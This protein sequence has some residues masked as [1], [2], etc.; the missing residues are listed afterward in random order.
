MKNLLAI[1]QIRL[2]RK[3]AALLALGI[4]ALAAAPVAT[5]APTLRLTSGATVVTV[6]DGGANDSNPAAGAITYVG[7]VG[8]NWIISADT[9]RTKP[10]LG[11]ATE[12]EI[13]LGTSSRSLLAG[14]LTIEFSDDGFGPSRGN[15]TVTFGG[16]I[17]GNTN[18]T[19]TNTTLVN[20][21]NVLFGGALLTNLGPYMRP[22]GVSIYAFN[23]TATAA[24]N[25]AG[26][27]SLT[28]RMVIVH[29]SGGTSGADSALRFIPTAPT[30]GKIGN[31]VW[32]DLNANGVQDPL[33]PGIDGVT[34]VLTDG[35][36]TPITSTVTGLNGAYEFPGLALGTYKVSVDAGSAPLAG[37]LPSPTGAG[38]PAT[39]SNASP[40]TVTLTE[41]NPNDDSVD[42]GFYLYV[43]PTG[44]IGDYV[45]LDL[46][47][48]GIQDPNESGI[49]NVVVILKDGAGQFIESTHTAADGSYLF[50]GKTAGDYIVQ[51]D[52]STLP[53]GLIPTYSYVLGSFD[54]NDSNDNPYHVTLASKSDMDLTV[55][56][57]YIPAPAGSIGD[58]VWRD[59]DGDG[60][61]DNALLEPGIPGVLVE[62]YNADGTMLLDTEITD[63][64][65]YYLFTGLA[66]GTYI[67][68][69]PNYVT[70]AGYVY[71]LTT[72]N[73]AG[74]TTANDSNPNPSTVTLP[75]NTS[76][77]TDV[78]FGYTPVP[79]SRIG[80]FVWN[81]ANDNGIQDPTET[82]IGGVSVYLFNGDDLNTAIQTTVT[83]P[84]GSYW[85]NDLSSGIYSVAVDLSSPSLAG[86]IATTPNSSGDP[87][88]D[89]NLNP[90]TVT[91]LTNTETNDAIDFGF[92]R[93]AGAIGD[94][95]WDDLDFDGVQDANEP[96]I[97]GVTVDLYDFDNSLIASQ[98]TAPDGSYLFTGLTKG[99]YVVVVE[100][101]QFDGTG[102][103]PTQVNASGNPATDSNNNPQAV[104]LLT[105]ISVDDT[106]DF[107][108]FKPRGRIGNF[109][110]FDANQD[111][112]QSNGETGIANV[113]VKLLDSTNTEIGSVLT[114]ADGSYEFSGLLKGTYT[115]VVDN[116][117][118]LTAGY[119]PTNTNAGAPDVDSNVNPATVTLDFNDSVDLTIDFGYVLTPRGSIGDFVWNDINANG[120]QDGSESGIQG[121]TIRLN[122]PGNLVM[123]TT[124]DTGGLYLFDGLSAGTYTVTVVTSTLP[125]GFIASPTS[126]PGSNSGNDS[127]VNPAT[128][129]FAT[130]TASNMTIDFGYNKPSPLSV[131]CPARA[132]VFGQ[133]YTSFAVASG[134]V[135]PYTFT[136]ISGAL[137]PG[138]TLNSA[139]G[140]IAGTPTSEGSYSFTIQV[141]D[142]TRATAT[143][144]IDCCGGGSATIVSFNTPTGTLPASQT[145]NVAGV[146]ITAYGFA[147][148]GTPKALF[149][150]NQGGTESGL[151]I[152]GSNS[153]NEI[154]TANF[155]QLDLRNLI[156]SNATGVCLL[157]NSVQSGEAYNVYGSNT[158]GSIGTLLGGNRTLGNNFF[159]M[160]GFPTYRYISVRAASTATNWCTTT[161]S[162][163][164]VGAVSFSLPNC[165][166]INVAPPPNSGIIG[167]LVWKDLNSNGI[168]DSGEPG[169]NGVAVT[170]A[171]PGNVVLATQITSGNGGYLFTGLAA[172]TYTVTVNTATLPAGLMATTTTAAGSTT[173][174]DSNSNPATVTLAT[175]S[176]SNRTI[177][178]GYKP[179]PSRPLTTY[180][181]GG[182]G[183][184]PCGNNP[185][186]LLA[187]NFATVFPNGLTVGGGKT[188]KFTSAR[189]IENFLPCGGTAAKLQ[190][191][192]INPTTKL[193]VLAGQVVALRLGV[194]FS[195]AGV[196]AG[197]LANATFVSG[198]FAGQ[199]VGQ[200]L[201]LAE[202]ALGGAPLP[203]GIS[204]ADLS[205]ACAL[206]N[207]NYDEGRNLGNLNP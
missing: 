174:N 67:V 93:P 119:I 65:G 207:E 92:L 20:D 66:K 38:T 204:Y 35:A 196:T 124:T 73:H 5:A 179:I 44:K 57:G 168:Q 107:G 147:N 58:Y 97:G 192:Y 184:S 61:Q 176:S 25:R 42:F 205:N 170:L 85:F 166:V 126:A 185:G 46:D 29:T 94:F 159:A 145:Y 74:S 19:F 71:N 120:I 9:A 91:L 146:P 102:Y 202:A 6:I 160:P 47:Q 153:A 177:D 142:F 26:N 75:L 79:A 152:S 8:T 151:G 100:A 105:N 109:V 24:L 1:N 111:G 190:Q 199:S 171:G 60:I 18:S 87:A 112:L 14:T 72:P 191:S 103:L 128:V 33:E 88:T 95:V 13:T 195:N 116:A 80:N 53:P 56:F 7:P 115:V 172:G 129:V 175:S 117:A 157:V 167:D 181:M 82:G 62:L 59:L 173:A 193:G 22:A 127:N 125:A 63:T 84:D 30:L 138:V 69:V 148:D 54:S 32:N 51:V 156:T 158:L 133:P 182:W 50:T 104:E 162:D 48:D 180:T 143:T 89:S 98:V 150:K 194:S 96:G 11:T 155:V 70:L 188:L 108:Y 135:Q 144:G 134:G 164:L 121:V 136:V 64:D 187:R 55:D 31:F 76:A 163:V 41:E 3:T 122:G 52:T 183:S 10:G 68:K 131:T 21:A 17:G 200:V 201:A 114:A 81:D 137:P 123:T 101:A 12:P 197:G 16:T 40:S 83:L 140:E 110:W 169:I 37:Y 23:G 2:A 203:P 178:F 198:K 130:N 49:P 189:G 99:S 106:I 141:S 36:G 34:V 139:T 113:P 206:V 165:C 86:F 77:I 4:A 39:D 45:W 186:T 154:T 90:E 27:Y 161:A 15:A 78:D 149:G 43:P 28:Q 118:L 132:A